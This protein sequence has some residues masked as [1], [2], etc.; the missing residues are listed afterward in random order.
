L[1][2]GRIKIVVTVFHE[3]SREAILINADV[4]LLV[5]LGDFNCCFALLN[6][7]FRIVRFGEIKLTELLLPTRRK[8]PGVSKTSALPFPV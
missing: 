8:T 2:A 4:V 6:P 3:L 7:D 5:N 1:I